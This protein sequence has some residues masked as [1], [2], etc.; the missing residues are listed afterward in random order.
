VVHIQ[1]HADVNGRSFCEVTD[2]WQFPTPEAARLVASQRGSG[3]EAVGLTPWQPA[4]PTPAITGLKPASEF[5]DP[6]Q[7]PSESP[8]VR[9]FEVT[10]PAAPSPDR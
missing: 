6:M 4:F 10:P 3:Y 2:R 5:R 9:I 8:M 7:S 1:D